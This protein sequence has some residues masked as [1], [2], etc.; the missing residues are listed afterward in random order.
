[1]H[2]V[3]W[4]VCNNFTYVYLSDTAP[5]LLPRHYGSISEAHWDIRG[6][7]FLDY[8]SSLYCDINIGFHDKAKIRTTTMIFR[9]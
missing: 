2:A 4:W 5:S 1:M 6:V 7:L 8:V 9:D 3:S